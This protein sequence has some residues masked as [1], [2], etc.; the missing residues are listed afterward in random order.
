[1]VPGQSPD[2]DQ[3][4]KPLEAPWIKYSEITY[5]FIKIYPP[6]PVIK[7]TQHFFFKNLI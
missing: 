1:M 3:A 4:A 2:G 5:F 7:L 6:Q